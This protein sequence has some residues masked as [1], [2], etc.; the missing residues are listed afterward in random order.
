MLAQIVPKE[1]KNL[2]EDEHRQKGNR[3]SRVLHLP[4]FHK[5]LENVQEFPKEFKIWQYTT[6]H[7]GA[8][9]QLLIESVLLNMKYAYL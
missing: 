3:F 6:L 4:V 2:W 7:T 1:E 9:A 8:M 5:H